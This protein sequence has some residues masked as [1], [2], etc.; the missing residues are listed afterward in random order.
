[1]SLYEKARKGDL[2][3]RKELG[4]IAELIN[5]YRGVATLSVTTDL[6]DNNREGRGYSFFKDEFNSLFTPINNKIIIYQYKD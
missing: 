6:L 1:M 4:Y 5:K 2:F 3:K